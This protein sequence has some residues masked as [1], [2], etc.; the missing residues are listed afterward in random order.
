MPKLR[1]TDATV[2]ALKPPPKPKQVDY[3]DV[4]FPALALRVS[5]AGRKTFILHG[6]VGGKLTRLKLGNYPALTLAEARKKADAWKNDAKSGLDPKAEEVKREAAAGANAFAAVV[7]RFLAANGNRLRATTLSEYRRFL[8][9]PDVTDW[10]T[11][12]IDMISRTD[13]AAVLDKIDG[14]GKASSS[15]HA[16]SYLRVLFNWTADR[17]L[18]DRPPTDRI[19]ARHSNGSRD[20]VLSADEMALV[21][22][23]LDNGATLRLLH[24]IE[25]LPPMSDKLRTFVWLMLLTGQRRGEVAGMMWQE[26]VG[27]GSKEARWEIP[28]SRTKNHREH[29]VP[30]SRAAVA[31]LKRRRKA[32]DGSTVFGV[33]DKPLSGYSKAKRALDARVAAI[34]K[35]LDK[36][37]PAEW[38]WHDLRRTMVTQMN[39]MGIAP[40]IVEAVVNHISGAA[41][42]GVA[43]VYNRALYLPERR[44]ALEAWAEYVCRLAA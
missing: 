9:G 4:L 41:K 19:R 38:T 10:A 18:I 28:G 40:H 44:Q 39:E 43:G 35:A 15:N 7:E 30:L 13:V 2:K 22:A 34:A 29:I 33:D 23:A 12:P 20:R 32:D 1:L 27:L 31:A 11:R 37:A 24:G 42:A 3:F 16:L 14:R 17:D 21:V 6:R 5:Y 25:D 8:T 36:P 26:I